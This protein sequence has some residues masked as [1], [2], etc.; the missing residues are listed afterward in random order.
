MSDVRDAGYDDFVDALAD[1]EGYYVEC[2]EGHGSLPPRRACPH[3]ASRDLSEEPLPE[4][5]TVESCTEIHV[6][7]PSFA[8][9]APYV[10]A[11]VDF[12]PVRVTGQVLA[13][14]EDVE[15]GSTVAPTVTETATEGDRLVAFE[16][17]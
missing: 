13:D 2:D 6:P 4:T 5:G 10:V 16:L 17:R 1:G 11:V 7:T 12:G 3:C 15:I 8:D 9:D 14:P